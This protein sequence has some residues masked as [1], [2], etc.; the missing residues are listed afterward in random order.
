LKSAVLA[1]VCAIVA[2]AGTIVCLLGMIAV[3]K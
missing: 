3:S 1:G 2:L